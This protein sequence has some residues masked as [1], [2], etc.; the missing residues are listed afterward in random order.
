MVRVWDGAKLCAGGQL[1]PLCL[2]P[3]PAE[4]I[5]G[6]IH[7]VTYT[8]AVEEDWWSEGTATAH[9]LHTHPVRV[10]FYVLL[11]CQG[12]RCVRPLWAVLRAP[13]YR[14]HQPTVLSL[15]TELCSLA[16]EKRG[17]VGRNIQTVGETELLMM[18]QT[19]YWVRKIPKI[20]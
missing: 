14:C 18:H 17:V 8:L 6:L 10:R 9:G 19:T 13:V 16:K 3:G 1:P 4:C 12:Q 20:G 15:C 7:T 5:I 11:C 2:P